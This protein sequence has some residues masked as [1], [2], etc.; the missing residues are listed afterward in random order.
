MDSTL[1]RGHGDIQT[2]VITLVRRLAPVIPVA[3]Q[4][5]LAQDIAT[6]LASQPSTMANALFVRQSIIR[7]GTATREQVIDGL[8][9]WVTTLFDLANLQHDRPRAL[10]LQANIP[11]SALAHLAQ[12]LSRS[13]N[14]CILAVPHIGSVELFASVLKDRGINVGFVYTIGTRPTP[15]EQW[16]Y[17]GRAATHATPIAFGRR[18][19]GAEITRILRNGGLVVMVVDVYPS[20]RHHGIRVRIH[21][22]D[23]N[24]PPGPAR[25][26]RTGTL[27]LP[28][29]A[30]RR[31][32]DGFSM[33]ILDPINTSTTQPER[34]TPSDLTQRL[35]DR[36]SAFTAAQPEAF[37]LWHPIPNDPFLAVARKQRPDLIHGPDATPADDEAMAQSIEALRTRVV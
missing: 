29:F 18:A 14:G 26:A 15:T 31:T 11:G 1:P 19:T 27:V 23:F 13:R 28:G 10:D 37:W 34:D 16:I 3:R 6:V 30:S 20:A 36:V 32:E 17:R 22:A 33:V 8:A 5:F 24:Y 2:A 7:R 25:Y 12:A 21:G 4:P 9:T 35:A